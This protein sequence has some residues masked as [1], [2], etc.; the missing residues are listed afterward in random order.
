MVSRITRI[1]NVLLNHWSDIEIPYSDLIELKGK[2]IYLE[3]TLY[4]RRKL[5]RVFN[6]GT[7][8]HGGRFYGGWWQR[9]DGKI[10]KDIRINN[11]A[12]VEIDYSAIHVIMLYALIRIDYWERY[13]KDPYD[14]N[15]RFVNDP[16]HSRTISTLCAACGIF[17]G[18]RSW[19]IG[20]LP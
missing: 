6:N 16:E 3:E 13:S 4:R 1:N 15:V 17:E 20:I 18:S 19:V 10:R 9:V 8:D 14:I 7:F 2:G 5:N 11:L 12:T